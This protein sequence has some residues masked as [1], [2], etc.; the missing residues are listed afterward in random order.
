MKYYIGID[1][2]GTQI[3]LGLVANDTIIAR[4]DLMARSA[5]G[6]AIHLEKLEEAI[7][8]MMAECGV[9]KIEGVGLSFPGIVDVKKRKVLS[10]YGKYDDAPDIDLVQWA[11]DKWGASFF[12]DIDARMSL[13]G[14][15]RYGAAKGCDNAVMMTLGTGIGTAVVMEGSILRGKHFQGGSFCG[16]FIIDLD[17][18]ECSCGGRGC[19]EAQ[20]SSWSIAKQVQ[21]DPLLGESLL[22]GHSKVGFLEVFDAARRGDALACRLKESSMR[23]WSAGIVSLIHA[24]DPEVAIIGGGVMN[25][26]D[27]ILPYVRAFVERYACTPWGKVEVRSSELMNDS[28]ILGVCYCLQTESL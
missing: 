28:A 3:K 12:M 10:T 13:A 23:A 21:A 20:S 15:W 17:G 18:L 16:H 11:E 8:S 22:A 14:E 26:R 27:E 1:L 4:R 6:L 9:S 19:V 7:N 5:L 24:F 2:G 25:S